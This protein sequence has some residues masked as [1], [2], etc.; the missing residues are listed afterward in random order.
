MFE[1]MFWPKNLKKL[2]IIAGIQQ[3]LMT[4]LSLNAGFACLCFGDKEQIVAAS[5]SK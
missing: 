5:F 2:I 3:I 1:D 4:G